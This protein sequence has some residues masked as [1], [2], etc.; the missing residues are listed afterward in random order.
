MEYILICDMDGT[1]TG[2][3]EAITEFNRFISSH[4]KTFYLVYSSGRFKASMISLIKEES[5]PIPNALIANIGTEIYY[6]PH[7]NPDRDW[8]KRLTGHWPKEEILSVLRGFDIQPQPYMK[9]FVLG[10]YVRNGNVVKNIEKKLCDQVKCVYTKNRYLDVIPA[11]AGKGSAAEHL[12]RKISLPIICCG[13][14]ENDIGMLMKGDYGVLVGNASETIK[15]KMSTQS[16]LYI[17]G[18][19]CARGVLEGLRELFP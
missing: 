6:A 14:S 1:L 11:V 8:E 15:K 12:K 19:C 13:D 2:D 3:R 7:W 4:R 17:S 16:H 10:Y 9:K 5:L 18:L